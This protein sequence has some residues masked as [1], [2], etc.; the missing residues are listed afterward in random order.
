MKNTIFLIVLDG[1]SVGVQSS[2][3]LHILP[4]NKSDFTDSLALFGWGI[5]AFLS[6]YF[7]A[8][9]TDLI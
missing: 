8:R 4:F 7:S 9:I 2:T 5:G 6:G 1:L 3:L